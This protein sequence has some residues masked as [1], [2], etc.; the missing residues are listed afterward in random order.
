MRNS[1]LPGTG[2]ISPNGFP[3]TLYPHGPKV[4][5]NFGMATSISSSLNIPVGIFGQISLREVEIF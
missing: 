4:G 5:T 3:L 1:S 2:S